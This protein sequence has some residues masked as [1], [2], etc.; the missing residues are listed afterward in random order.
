V[1]EE[2]ALPPGLELSRTTPAFTE[3]TVPSGL[4]RAH[5]VSSHVWACLRVLDGTLTFVDEVSGARRLLHAGEQQ[6]ISPDAPHHVEPHDG[7]RFVVDF[8]R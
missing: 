2:I 4:L 3:G 7:A 8:Y 6:V 5:R 1:L